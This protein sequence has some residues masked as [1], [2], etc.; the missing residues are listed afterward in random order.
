M[1]VTDKTHDS[2]CED[3]SHLNMVASSVFNDKGERLGL[4]PLF[5]M[6]CEDDMERFDRW[7]AWNDELIVLSQKTLGGSQG[8][9]E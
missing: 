3:D 9:D 5:C 1:G 8:S 2:K 4:G 6:E 7:Q